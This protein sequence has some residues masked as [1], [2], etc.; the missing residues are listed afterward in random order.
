[1]STLYLTTPDTI[2]HKVDERL[3]VRQH[4]EVLLDVPL[5]KIEQVVAL[6]RVTLT[7]AIV[8]ELMSRKIGVCYLR[9][10]GRFVAR[11]EPEC[12]KNILLRSA[13]YRAAFDSIQSTQ[14]A[15]RFVKGKLANLRVA[16]KRLERE[17]PAEELTAA[18]ARIKKAERLVKTADSL[19][20]VRGYEG[21]AS[22][23]YFGVFNHFLKVEGFSFSRRLRRPPPDPVNALLSLGYSLLARDIQT[24]CNLVGF[25]PYLGFL[26]SERYGRP[27]LALDLM[28]EFRPLIVDAAVLR[29]I[30]LKMLTPAD[31]PEDL[32]GSVRLEDQALKTF[33]RVY[34]ERKQT[35]LKH[36]VLGIKVTYQRCFELQARLLSRYLT[37]ELEQYLP[38]IVQ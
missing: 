33:L 26:H 19:D 11:L 14:L 2:V 35:T 28:E 24:A 34:E 18:I 9:P 31:F 1:M 30:N 4:R 20:S 27:S 29:C 7:A 37:G 6:G 3:Q 23:A 13:Q 5:L 36:P 32:G 17:R 25:D 15:T 10:N 21:T 12:N 22:A 16:L 38:L 8:E